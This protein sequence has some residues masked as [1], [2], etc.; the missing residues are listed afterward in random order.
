MKILNFLLAL[1]QVFATAEEHKQQSASCETSIYGCC[2]DSDLPKMDKQG[3]NCFT[4]KTIH[5][6]G[7]IIGGCQ[8]TE[9][10][11]CSDL[12]TAKADEDGSNCPNFTASPLN[13]P[14]ENNEQLHFENLHA[15]FVPSV[16]CK[17]PVDDQDVSILS[18]LMYLENVSSLSLVPDGVYHSVYAYGTIVGK[19]PSYYEFHY[20]MYVACPKCTALIEKGYLCKTEIPSIRSTHQKQ[21]R[22]NPIV[23]TSTT[24]PSISLHA[25]F[26]ISDT[27]FARKSP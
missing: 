1:G 3:S 18:A 26:N 21:G 8:G 2:A 9:F 6:E 10:G 12:L 24:P 16:V 4:F 13:T 27:S 15:E 20:E 5:E 7:D 14:E 19:T 22:I 23:N 17:N 25:F 11:C